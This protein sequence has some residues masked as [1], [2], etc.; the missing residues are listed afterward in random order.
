MNIQADN[1][2]VNP[3]NE[4]FADKNEE[5]AEE[6]YD[7]ILPGFNFYLIVIFCEFFLF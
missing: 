6:H 4:S 3:P 2:K 7:G 1:K 5:N